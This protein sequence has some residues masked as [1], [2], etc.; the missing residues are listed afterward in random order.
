MIHSICEY[1]G[2]RHVLLG[3]ASIPVVIALV[4]TVPLAALLHRFAR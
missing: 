3:H 1:E 2:L 4:G